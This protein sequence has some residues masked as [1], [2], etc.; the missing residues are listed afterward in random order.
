MEFSPVQKMLG[1]TWYMSDEYFYIGIIFIAWLRSSKV[2]MM[3]YCEST[4]NLRMPIDRIE[5]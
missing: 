3:Y 1:E 5:Y 4:V 2:I